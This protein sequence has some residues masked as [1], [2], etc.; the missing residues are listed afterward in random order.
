M[1]ISMGDDG[2][3]VN[4]KVCGHGLVRAEGIAVPFG[5]AAGIIICAGFPY[6]EVEHKD[7]DIRILI[8]RPADTNVVYGG[9][10]GEMMAPTAVT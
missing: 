6:G 3:H 4:G 9:M 10:C 1:G 8:K 2:A 5:F 7:I